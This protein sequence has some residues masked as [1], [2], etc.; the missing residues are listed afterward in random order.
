M[1]T[2]K[3]DNPLDQYLPSERE[4]AYI[5]KTR[6]TKDKKLA[7]KEDFTPIL[8]EYIYTV[9]DLELPVYYENLIAVKE[10]HKLDFEFKCKI[11][12]NKA[13]H[14]LLNPT[15]EDI[16]KHK[17]VVIVKDK[18]GKILGSSQCELIVSPGNSGHNQAVKLFVLGASVT[19][20]GRQLDELARLLDFQGNPDWQMLGTRKPAYTKDP[21]PGVYHEGQGGFTWQS[22][23]S[24]CLFNDNGGIVSKS[25]FI[26]P[27]SKNEIIFDPSKYAKEKL[28]G[29]SPDLVITMMGIN[30]NFWC[31]SKNYIDIEDNVKA[32]SGHADELISA[33]K[34]IWP[35]AEFAICT[36]PAVNIRDKAFEK[37]YAKQN[38]AAWT[39]GLLQR[40]E[41]EVGATSCSENAD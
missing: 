15:K 35:N 1:L 3:I 41:L 8:P 18:S 12:L 32:M 20:N 24:R 31:S 11:G 28:K 30:D 26:F 5:N 21:H 34:K 16:G 22:F 29:E 40:W 39:A 36:L 33:L 2:N 4:Q 10:S 9:V 7:L 19:N 38:P 23:L 27:N 17:F 13:D 6:S 37:N 14:Y 25:P